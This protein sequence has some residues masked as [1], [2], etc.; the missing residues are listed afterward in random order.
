[1]RLA[2]G[3]LFFSSDRSDLSD[4]SNLPDLA[5]GSTLGAFLDTVELAARFTRKIESPNFF[6]FISSIAFIASSSF[7]ISANP[8]PLDSPV[9][10]SFTITQDVTRPY[11]LNKQT[12][13]GCVS[14]RSILRMRICTV[15]GWLKKQASENPA[16]KP[17]DYQNENGAAVKLRKMNR[18]WSQMNTDGLNKIKKLPSFY[19][20][21]S[22]FI[23]VHLRLKNLNPATI[24]GGFSNP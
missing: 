23:R 3:G 1:M 7:G 16:P 9:F 17:A 13:S 6:P 18:S 11:F 15:S 20:S 12:I 2:L 4:R 10:S 21:L 24:H 14:L 8:N 19:S 22:A 5:G